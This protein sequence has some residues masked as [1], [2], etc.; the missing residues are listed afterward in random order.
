[1][2]KYFCSFGSNLKIMPFTTATFLAQ[3]PAVVVV[4]MSHNHLCMQVH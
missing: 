2:R 3:T 4:L 1:M